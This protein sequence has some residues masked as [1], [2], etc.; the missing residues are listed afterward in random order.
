M[1]PNPPKS[2]SSPLVLTGFIA[3]ALM[4]AD[5]LLV[6]MFT[7]I[8]AIPD[9]YLTIFRPSSLVASPVCS[10]TSEL[11]ISLFFALIAVRWFRVARVSSSEGGKESY[12]GLPVLGNIFL[13]V[14]IRSILW[15]L[16]SLSSLMQMFSDSRELVMATSLV[17]ALAVFILLKHSL[18]FVPLLIGKEGASSFFAASQDLTRG[19]IWSIV[20]L[21]FPPLALSAIASGA[22][23]GFSPDGRS[24]INVMVL[25]LASTIFPIV[26]SYLLLAYG[27]LASKRVTP[28]IFPEIFFKRSEPGFLQASLTPRGAA[29]VF[30]LAL[31]VWSSNIV[32][33]WSLA[34]SPEISLVA[35]SYSAP[36]SISL[37][38][39]LKD[40]TYK[41]RGLKPILFRVAGE[42]GDPITET[43]FRA[44][45]EGYQNNFFFDS[46][47][48]SE[49]AITLDFAILFRQDDF[50]KLKDLHLWYASTRILHLDLSKIT[51]AEKNNNLT[52][53]KEADIED[54]AEAHRILY[55]E[56]EQRSQPRFL[57]RIFQKTSGGRPLLLPREST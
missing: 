51:V 8:L 11:L 35:A 19:R 12:L 56:E 25:N 48:S 5:I 54:S 20:S 47:A 49:S 7:V 45:F 30:V 21:Y 3:S 53:S 39:S 10:L 23:S 44:I 41:M 16:I 43:P 36:G 32:Q 24:L 31:I 42:N 15:G 2:V 38:L 14:L 33:L 28:A 13:I 9:L 50:L 26:S 17:S 55:W 29:S 52:E 27:L 57:R 46:P 1:Q 6:S 37:K 34:P 40:P 18:F 4:R 22:I